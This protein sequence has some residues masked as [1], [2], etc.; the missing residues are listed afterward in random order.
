MYKA[1]VE[2]TPI[3]TKVSKMEGVDTSFMR[4][5]LKAFGK[6]VDNI[7]RA[8]EVYKGMGPVEVFT[9]NIVANVASTPF[10][11]LSMVD[12]FF[13]SMIYQMEINGFLK[14]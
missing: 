1:F 9:D 6:G 4:D 13:K 8:P 10:K 7:F 11:M 5:Y 3:T 14:Q 12:E 2:G